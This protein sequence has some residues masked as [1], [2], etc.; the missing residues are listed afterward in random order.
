[1][2]L[3]PVAYTVEVDGN[4]L[5]CYVDILRQ[6]IVPTGPPDI[7]PTDGTTQDFKHPESP[8][9]PDET[10]NEEEALEEQF[11]HPISLVR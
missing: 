6:W 3:G 7:L 1:M 5:K 10:N 9:T 8:G 2:Q 4:L 11:S